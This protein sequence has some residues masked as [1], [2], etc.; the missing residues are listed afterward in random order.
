MDKLAIPCLVDINFL[1]PEWT[2]FASFILLTSNLCVRY[3][4]ADIFMHAT[5]VSDVYADQ[6]VN[7]QI[8]DLYIKYI[9]NVYLEHFLNVYI[10]LILNVYI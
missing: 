3:L 5:D 1:S 6:N 2:K 10:D 7:E 9:L 4:L 8:I